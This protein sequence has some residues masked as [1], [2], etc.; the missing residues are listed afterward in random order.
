M[1][2]VF[3]TNLAVQTIIGIHPEERTTPQQVLISFELQADT[4]KAARSDD[5]ND[6]LDY[7]SAAQRVTELV[8]A[9]RFQLIET[10]AERIAAA[11]LEAYPIPRVVVEV[12]KPGALRD[13]E[14]VG[15]RIERG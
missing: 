15:V 14:T 1:D 8:A 10:M 3:V 6:A 7:H 4:T 2:T 5:I 13:A 9:G 12:R 11:L